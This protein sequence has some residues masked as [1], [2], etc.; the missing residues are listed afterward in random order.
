[1]VASALT[2]KE[3]LG[4]SGGRLDELTS[5]PHIKLVVKLVSKEMWI[6]P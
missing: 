5:V 2:Q 1:M 6:C 3:E 4:E